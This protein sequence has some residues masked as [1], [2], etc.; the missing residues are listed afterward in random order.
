[1][2]IRGKRVLITGASRGIGQQLARG[3]ADAGADV[4]LVARGSGPLEEVAARLGG[5]AY[6]CDLTNTTALRGLIARVERDGPVDIL[7]NNAG[8]ECIGRFNEMTAETLDFIIAL[9]V[10]AGAELFRQVLPGMLARGHG[11]LVNV[12]SMAGVSLPP[13][14][15][16][17]AATKAFVTHHTVNLAF[18]LQ[19]TP[20]G[21]T[22]VEIGEVADT[23][24]MEKGRS[25][26]A[27][28]AL[29][30]RMYR[31]KVSRLITPEEITDAV[32]NA[33]RHNKLSVRLPKRLA[34]SSMMV[35]L[36]RRSAWLMAR[37]LTTP[38]H[39]SGHHGPT[40][41]KA[42]L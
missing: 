21:V 7:V 39:Y 12:S 29:F 14:L 24:L 8:D 34:S 36:P 6:P 16:T 26:P 1:M 40:T 20:V 27:L 35:D 2:D 22:K 11:H 3:F 28:S 18:E 41:S 5:R 33:V 38:P 23:G 15:A 30:D 32:L 9:N 31:L 13:T 25:S 4:A 10:L 37:G 17:Y 19:D 42:E